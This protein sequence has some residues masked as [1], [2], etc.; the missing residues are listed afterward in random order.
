[1]F[2]T[3]VVSLVALSVAFVPVAAEARNRDG[4][5]W[6]QRKE[7]REKRSRISTGEAIAIGVGAFI[8]GAASRKQSEERA[9]DREVYDREY[10]YHY[11]RPQERTC[12][13]K[14]EPL[15]DSY[16]RFVRWAK[17]TACY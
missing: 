14:F 6:E 8:L 12:Y 16:G 5:G 15:Y 3:V 17:V 9:A 11:R 7:R 10:D 13:E 2:K 4:N 1:M